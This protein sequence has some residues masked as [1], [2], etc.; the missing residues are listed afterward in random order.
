[1]IKPG[2]FNSLFVIPILNILVLF[3]FVFEFLH[4][5]FAF[6]FAIIALTTLVRLVLQPFFNQ[7]MQTS[8]KMIE[9]KPQMD[10][11]TK[12]YKN[13]KKGLQQEQL[14]LYQQ[15]GI[16]P[17]AGCLFMIVQIPV[18]IALYQALLLFLQNTN[19]AKVIAD[20]NK[21]LYIPGV[22]ITTFDP[23]FFG[24]NLSVAPNVA[25]NVFYYIIPV[26]TAA[27][28]YFQV[29]V[30]TPPSAPAIVKKEGEKTSTQED[31]QKAMGTQMKYIFPVLIG[32]F[33]YTLPVGLSLYWNVFSLFSIIQY[34]NI[35]KPAKK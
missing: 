4:I 35:N 6:G 20:V 18:F 19:P 15:A 27:L 26:I 21:I 8:K 32:W 3:Y 13:D 2:F 25:G 11:L 1:M 14:K 22:R 9:I 34:R 33:A 31:F 7:Q 10:A 23:M 30:S 29:K 16:N 17:A 24:F 28:Q 5:P 12:K